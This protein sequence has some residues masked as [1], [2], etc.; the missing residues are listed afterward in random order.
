MTFDWNSFTKN[1]TLIT[2]GKI[3]LQR[4]QT[5][6]FV[7]K[8]IKMNKYKKTCG[9]PSHFQREPCNITILCMMQICSLF[10]DFVSVLKQV[11]D[12]Q[13]ETSIISLNQMTRWPFSYLTYHYL[14][15]T[16]TELNI[17]GSKFNGICP[18]LAICVLVLHHSICLCA[19]DVIL[20]VLFTEKWVSIIKLVISVL[21]SAGT[22]G[23]AKTRRDLIII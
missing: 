5:N 1:Y 14:S 3:T 4:K 19:V 6:K 16:S 13:N 2:P 17:F 21:Q 23:D 12:F 22:L 15:A 8:K 9:H 7:N 20:S 10:V 18:F 11:S